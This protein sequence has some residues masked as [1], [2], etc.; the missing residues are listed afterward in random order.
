[1]LAA[2]KNNGILPEPPKK[3]KIVYND[4][5]PLNCALSNLDYIDIDKD[6][7]KLSKDILKENLAELIHKKEELKK[8]IDELDK[9]ILKV[10]SKIAKQPRNTK[11]EKLEKGESIE[12]TS[13]KKPKTESRGRGRP[14][15]SG[16]AYLIDSFAQDYEFL[17]IKDISEKLCLSESTTSVYATKGIQIP[18]NPRYSV[19]RNI[20]DVWEL[21]GD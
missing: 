7:Y 9:E 21:M 15:G 18:N 1:M 6:E 2:W 20:G 10:A 12:G 4:D 16:G 19:T 8:E 5:N 3:W 11:Y 14:L 17:S 13:I